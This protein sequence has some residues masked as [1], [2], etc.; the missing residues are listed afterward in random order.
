MLKAVLFDFN[1]VIINDELLH[2]HLTEQILLEE[3]LRPQPGEYRQVCLGCSDLACLNA[4][5][6]RRGRVPSESYL[7]QLLSRKTQAYQ[8]QLNQLERLPL[9]PGLE[10]LIFQLGARELK[11]AV[12]SG[13]MLKEVELV[14]DRA[15]LTEYFKVIVAADGVTASKPEPDGYLLAVERLNQLYPGF[16]L[17]ASECLAIE[18]TPSGIEAAKRAGMPVV[19]VA[20]TYPLHM[21]QRLA[22]WTVDYLCDLEIDRVQQVY[23]RSDQ[24]AAS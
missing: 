5:L 22:N 4:L 9:Y 7:T 11:L 20:N 10:D 14:L 2:Q 21:L 24:Q 13:A 16:N 3:N 15:T 23:S 17:Q 18:D 6:T 12:V 1:G 8:H 19:G